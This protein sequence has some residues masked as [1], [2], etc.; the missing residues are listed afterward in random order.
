MN[1]LIEL[2][3]KELSKINGG[4]IWVARGIAVWVITQVIDGAIEGLERPCET[5]C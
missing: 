1:N 5:K 2:D 3:S 4:W